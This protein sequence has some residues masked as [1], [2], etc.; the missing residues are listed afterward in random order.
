MEKTPD[1]ILNW[2]YDNFYGGMFNSIPK[3]EST[4]STIKRLLSTFLNDYNTTWQRSHD[5]IFTELIDD[6]KI[7]NEESDLYKIIVQQVRMISNDPNYL[8]PYMM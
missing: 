4:N 6:Y 1:G 2:I 5:N 7:N 3:E 8:S